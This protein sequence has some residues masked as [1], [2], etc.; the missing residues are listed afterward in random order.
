MEVESRLWPS[1]S[2]PHRPR[3]PRLPPPALAS[4]LELPV[5]PST[6]A[7]PAPSSSTSEKNQRRKCRCRG[8][9]KPGAG[10]RRRRPARP[11]VGATAGTQRSPPAAPPEFSGPLVGGRLLWTLSRPDLQDVPSPACPKPLCPAPLSLLCFRCQEMSLHHH[12]VRE[13]QV[14]IITVLSHGLTAKPCHATPKILHSSCLHPGPQPGPHTHCTNCSP[15]DSLT[16]MPD[17]RPI[18]V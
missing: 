6:P 12:S 3:L 17:P 4:Q 5:Q 11:N 9:K 8:A 16:A 14:P 18:C 2:S 10:A 7:A 13:L 1:A 15:P